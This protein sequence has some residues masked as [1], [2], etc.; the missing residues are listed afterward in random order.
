MNE[1]A[2]IIKSD[3]FSLTELHPNLVQFISSEFKWSM[4]GY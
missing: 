3:T 2:K 1:Q 4:Q